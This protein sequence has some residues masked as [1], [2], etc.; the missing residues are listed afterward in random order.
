M[1]LY[2]AKGSLN[3]RKKWFRFVISGYIL[4]TET[5]SCRLLQG[6]DMDWNLEKLGKRF[7]VKYYVFKNH[8]K[9]YCLV[10][11]DEICSISSDIV[12]TSAQKWPKTAIS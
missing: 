12:M 9:N 6:M 1:W 2:S 7:Q 10:L 5:V 8:Q 3:S 11:S 4:G